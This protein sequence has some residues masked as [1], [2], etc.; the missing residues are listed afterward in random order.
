MVLLGPKIFLVMIFNRNDFMK[1]DL[2]LALIKLDLIDI[3]RLPYNTPHF[4]ASSITQNGLFHLHI[5]T[6]FV[7]PR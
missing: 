4:L 5:S 1:F 3:L 2:W 7:L 6:V